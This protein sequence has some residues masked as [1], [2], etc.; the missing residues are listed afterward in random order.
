[1][2]LIDKLKAGLQVS[3]TNKKIWT[4]RPEILLC[5]QIPDPMHGVAPRV[6]LGK[7]WWDKTRRLAYESTN[8]HCIA[9]GVDKYYAKWHKWL[10]AH[11]VYD[12]DYLLGRMTY[13]ET[14]PLCH[15]CHNFIHC[16][17]LQ[18]LKDKGEISN[19][20]YHAILDHG[21]NVLTAA[22]LKKPLPRGAQDGPMADWGDWRLVLPNPE[23]RRLTLAKSSFK[24]TIEY[25]P[26][27]KNLDEWKKEYEGKWHN[28][29]DT[30]QL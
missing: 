17:R 7:E 24:E 1:M 26:K 30:T 12:I 20:K 21:L 9:C 4:R 8:F 6:I 27:F 22:G 16:G 14:V 15:F 5:P 29:K 23:A 19:E 10:E 13:L 25:P 11:E 18:A 28:R 2:G 3:S